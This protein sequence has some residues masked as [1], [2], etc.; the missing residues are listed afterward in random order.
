MRTISTF[1]IV[2]R[3]PGTGELGYYG[4]EIT[5]VYDEASKRAFFDY[6]GVENFEERICEGDFFDGQILDILLKN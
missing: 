3:D 4:G 6:C 2:A 5:G 1:S